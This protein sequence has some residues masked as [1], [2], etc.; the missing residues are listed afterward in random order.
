M[1][2]CSQIIYF[3]KAIQNLRAMF[4]ILLSISNLMR[5]KKRMKN[6]KPQLRND[7][8]IKKNETPQSI[9]A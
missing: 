4:C 7:D 8:E 2:R 6:K 9:K 3:W 5:F 1:G